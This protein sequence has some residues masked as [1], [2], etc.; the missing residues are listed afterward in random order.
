[1]SELPKYTLHK[2]PQGFVITS[3]EEPYNNDLCL[4]SNQEI[5]P[6]DGKQGEV[7]NYELCKKIIV[8]QNNIDFSSLSEEEQKII[9]YFDI[10]EYAIKQAE[11]SSKYSEYD[12]IEGFIEGFKKSQ[13]IQGDKLFIFE[14]WE[15]LLE[16]EEVPNGIIF[17]GLKPM[18]VITTTGLKH[19]SKTQIKLN[20]GKVK[21][22]KT[23]F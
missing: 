6:F 18:N 1:M 12:Y 19:G 7:W 14:K 9:G 4:Y 15:V 17:G 13:E 16:T 11:N 2:L 3:N 5:M 23:L 20:Q 8:E 21:I 22:L 10:E